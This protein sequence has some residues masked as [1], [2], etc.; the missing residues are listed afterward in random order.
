LLCDEC[1]NVQVFFTVARDWRPV[2]AA[3][4]L[5]PFSGP[6]DSD[7]A[8]DRQQ[9]RHPTPAQHKGGLR[10]ASQLAS[11]TRPYSFF[12]DDLL[13]HV[14]VEPE[15][16]HSRLRFELSSRSCRSSRSPL[17]PNPAY[18]FFHVVSRLADA[19]FAAQ[20]AYPRA[21][22]DLVQ[23]LAKSPLP[24]SLPDILVLLLALQKTSPNAAASTYRRPSFRVFGHPMGRKRLSPVMKKSAKRWRVNKPC[25]VGTGT[26]TVPFRNLF[27]RDSS[28]TSFETA[29]KFV[30]EDRS[31]ETILP[32]FTAPCGTEDKAAATATTA[33]PARI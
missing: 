1:L 20:V 30:L 21:A 23:Q 18:F 10:P 7:S 11:V 8:L 3:V 26:T 14:P 15:I 17:S 12:S 2:P 32:Y 5:L 6:C 16:R 24:V 27:R 22:F 9:P 29:A 33:R 4:S 28:R 25:R 13:W 19:V 31:S